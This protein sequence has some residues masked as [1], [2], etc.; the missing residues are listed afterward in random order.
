MLRQD[1]RQL[2]KNVIAQMI[3]P[4]VKT[5][6][7]VSIKALIAE[8]KMFMSYTPSYKKT[9]LG[10]QRALEMIHGNWEESYAKLPKLFGALQSC[11]HGTVV[12]A[13]TESL[14]EGRQKWVQC[15]DEGK[16]W[17][18]MNTNFLESVN[19]MF[20]NTRHLSVS[21]LVEE[22]YFKTAQVFAN[23][24]RQTGSHYSEVIFNVMNSSQQ[25]SNTH[26]VNEFDK[27]NLTFIITETQSPLETSD[28]LVGL[29]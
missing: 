8:I 23:K 10:K 14:Y 17:G 13:Q 15:F 6:S 24:G 4:I 18:H 29:E 9:W 2:D 7:T 12:A 11:V 3:Q 21:S 20:K 28:H 22:T 1:H 5:N 26:I 25:E 16:R 27:H 19:C